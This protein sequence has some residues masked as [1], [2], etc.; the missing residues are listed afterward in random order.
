ME[1]PDFRLYAGHFNS[2]FDGGTEEAELSSADALVREAYRRYKSPPEYELFDLKDDPHEWRNLANVDANKKVMKKL[3]EA[4]KSWQQT[5]RD[6]LAEPSILEAYV[7]E[8]EEVRKKYPNHSYQKD[9]SFQWKFHDQFRK[10]VHRENA[11][12]QGDMK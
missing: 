8:M 3:Q 11:D 1:N 4:L 2:H 7:R 9:S 6:P 12:I 10:W 5:T